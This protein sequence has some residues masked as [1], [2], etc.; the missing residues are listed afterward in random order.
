MRKLAPLLLGLATLAVAQTPLYHDA[1]GNIAVYA[2]S[3]RVQI[4][5]GRW[6]FDASSKAKPVH[7]VIRDQGLDFY[8]ER[9]H[10]VI[11]TKGGKSALD[12]ATATGNVRFVK[13]GAGG[14]SEL[15]GATATYAASGSLAKLT[16]TGGVR[17]TDA[18]GKQSLVARATK[19]TATL[20]PG[21]KASDPL[22]S[23]TLEG[24]V[25]VDGRQRVSPTE[26]KTL[27]VTARRMEL[28]NTLDPA[29]LTLSGGV[30][31]TGSFGRM[32]LSTAILTIDD[33]GE[34]VSISGS[35]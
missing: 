34:I 23:A 27:H 9:V 33:R 2:T 26:T 31:A 17:L 4:A 20:S 13:V 19:A 18:R 1:A 3:G 15:T 35:R 32:S 24:S 11:T 6:T 8:A 29:K 14:R 12:Q 25:V 16:L 28:D 7:V 10:G 30:V 5:K 21:A 22:R